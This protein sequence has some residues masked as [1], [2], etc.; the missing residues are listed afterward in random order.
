MKLSTRSRY[1]V[2][3]LLE[4]ARNEGQPPLQVSEISRRQKIPAKYIEQL[5][6]TLKSQALISSS[7][8]PKGGY[9]LAI[10][11]RQIHLGQIVRIF[12]GQ[13]D[14]VECIGAPGKCPKANDCPVR[15]AWG[16]A[17]KALFEQLD[18]ISINDLACSS[19]DL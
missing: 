15:K 9:S 19:P 8:G 4:L 17:N 6:R 7:R 1:S 3:I 11:A 16:Q 18:A 13:P 2:R 10:A 14:L 5:I 12:E